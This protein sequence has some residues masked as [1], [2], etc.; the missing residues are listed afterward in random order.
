MSPRL[1]RVAGHD[2]PP[3]YKL[4]KVATELRRLNRQLGS[5]GRF[6][7][8]ASCR[9]ELTELFSLD[10]VRA[11]KSRTRAGMNRIAATAPRPKPAAY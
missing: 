4:I 6:T 11:S 2:Q 8:I 1:S 3:C 5:V 7:E 10:G 9:L